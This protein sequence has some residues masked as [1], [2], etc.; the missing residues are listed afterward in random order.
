MLETFGD[1]DMSGAAIGALG[2]IEADGSLL[3]RSAV[4]V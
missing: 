3:G 4:S 2:L 1:A